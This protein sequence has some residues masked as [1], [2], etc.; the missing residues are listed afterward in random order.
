[1]L[2]AKTPNAEVIKEREKVYGPPEKGFKRVGEAW[3][4]L[5]NEHFLCELPALPPHLVGLMLASLKLQRAAKPYEGH[6]DNYVDATNYV[7]L[8]QQLDRRLDAPG[9]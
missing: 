6:L 1:M 7:A 9:A 2:D 5:L 4:A 8:A 3:A